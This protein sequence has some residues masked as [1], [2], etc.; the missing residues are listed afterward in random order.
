MA[1]GFSYSV[2]LLLNSC[3]TTR[4]A[5]LHPVPCLAPVASRSASLQLA[6]DTTQHERDC[7]LT[8]VASVP[9][10]QHQI[11]AVLLVLDAPSRSNSRDATPF[12]SLDR[13]SPMSFLLILALSSYM[14]LSSAKCAR[15]APVACAP[16]KSRPYNGGGDLGEGAVEVSIAEEQ[17][18]LT[19]AS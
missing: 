5:L 11:R 16:A 1:V 6:Y 2:A 4:F 18:S 13:A 8:G 7:R 17:P 15:C 19:L 14:A 10:Q 12:S 3:C 9:K